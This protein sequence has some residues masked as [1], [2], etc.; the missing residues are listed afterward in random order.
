[1]TAISADLAPRSE[2]IEG[3]LD[4]SSGVDD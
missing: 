2:G 1:M 3:R 4:L